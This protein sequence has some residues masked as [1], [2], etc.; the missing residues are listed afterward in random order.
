MTTTL[1]PTGPLE[2][3]ADGA[4]SRHYQVCVNSRPVGVADLSTDRR[5]G[6]TVAR[7]D[8][9]GIDE[10]DRRRGRGTVAALAAEEIVRGWG[11]TRIEVTVPAGAGAALGLAGALGYVERNRAM[12]KRVGP[13]APTLPDGV[14]ARPMTGAEFAVWEERSKEEYARD[15]ITRGVPEAEARAKTERDHATELPRGADTPGMVFS[16][17]EQDGETVG[18]LWVAVRADDAYVYDVEVAEQHRGKGHGRSLMLL[19]ER[20]ALTAG[21]TVLGLN[22]FAGNTPARTLYDSLG[23]ETERISLYKALL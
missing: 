16:V 15:W 20:H 8:H 1:R 19:A 21:R 13:S 7:I 23:Y 14:R 17:L 22:V 3:A 12:R 18:I 4:L 6:P 9:L 5:F 2:R 10:P 11:C